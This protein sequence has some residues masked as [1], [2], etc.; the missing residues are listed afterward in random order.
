M[1]HNTYVL[2]LGDPFQLPPV[3]A[4]NNNILAKP[5]VFLDEIQRQAKDSEIIRLTM[6]IRDRKSLQLLNGDQVKVLSKSDL[7]DGM[8]LW[9]DQTIVGRN[10]TRKQYNQY[11][12]EKILGVE[13]T[14]PV[15]GD[16]II[17]LRNY[18]DIMSMSDEPLVNGTIGTIDT[19][20]YNMGNIFIDP[21]MTINFT[22]DGLGGPSQ[23]LQIKADYQFLTT[24]EPTI[25]AQNFK[26]IPKLLQPCEFD[27]GYAI[28]CHKAQGSEYSKVLV[29]DEHLHSIDHARWLYTAATRAK[30]K[31]VII[32]D[33]N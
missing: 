7:I 26:E 6:D 30:D 33:Y 1:K 11:L 4:E 2:A 23:F 18:W 32:K 13:D 31:L 14:I 16:K 8:F 24:G 17:C 9:A 28:T 22:A 29:L 27:Y 21:I 15:E 20:K 19:I 10:D 3:R 25:T 5:H 12:R